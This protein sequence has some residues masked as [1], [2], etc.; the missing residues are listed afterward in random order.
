M[1]VLSTQYGAGSSN[2][3][4]LFAPYFATVYATHESSA[5]R[6]ATPDWSIVGHA[7]VPSLGGNT[8]G[9]ECGHHAKNGNSDNNGCP[10]SLG[11][12]SGIAL[13]NGIGPFAFQR[14]FHDDSDRFTAALAATP[15]KQ[16][17]EYSQDKAFLAECYGWVRDAA[18]FYASYVVR[19][20]ATGKLDIPFSCGEEGC[21]LRNPSCCPVSVITIRVM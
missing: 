19:N 5:A 11:N 4:E 13:V 18:E 7:P 2:H 20:N 12:F 17:W 21:V 3:L 1:A 6:A 14:L 15:M 10:S 8:Y 16:Y 9:F